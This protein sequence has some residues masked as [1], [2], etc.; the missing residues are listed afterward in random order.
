M[1]DFS[2]GAVYIYDYQANG[3]WLETILTVNNAAERANLGRRVSLHGDRAVASAPSDNANGQRSGSAYLFERQANGEWRET[4]L[5]P[6]DGGRSDVFGSSVAISEDI[7]LVGAEYSSE[8]NT[9]YLGVGGSVYVFPTESMCYSQGEQI[10]LCICRE[11]AAGD[12]CDERPLCGNG[13]VEE[14]EQCD[15]GNQRGGDGCSEECTIQ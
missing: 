12:F 13:I 2:L 3:S 11:G 4:K 15:D 7:I 6:S 1:T 8:L 9:G 10:G 5:I 14:A